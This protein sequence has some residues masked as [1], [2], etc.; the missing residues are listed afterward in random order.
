MLCHARSIN[1][2]ASFTKW[3]T[4]LASLLSRGKTQSVTISVNASCFS[5]GNQQQG[6]VCQFSSF[7]LHQ[8]TST[9]TRYY[10]FQQLKEIYYVKELYLH[11]TTI[12]QKNCYLVEVFL[13]VFSIVPTIRSITPE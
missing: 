4:V 10:S 3:Q 6:Q 11:V 9:L 2:S 12:Y 7:I 13:L 5:A 1:I 8:D